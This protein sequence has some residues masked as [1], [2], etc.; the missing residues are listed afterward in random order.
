LGKR[1]TYD[2]YVNMPDDGNR[3]EIDD[4]VLMVMEPAPR[5]QHQ[6]LLVRLVTYFELNCS[7]HGKIL[8]APVDVK[9]AD[10]NT[11]QPDLVFVSNERK[12]IITEM[13]IEGAPDLVVEI[14]SPSTGKRDKTKKKETY[15]RFGV[16]EYWVL[17]PFYELLEQFI[18]KDGGYQLE[19]VY[20]PD[21]TVTS[22]HFSCIN[23]PLGELFSE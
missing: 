6:E 15:E 13:A 9:F 2:D 5:I 20:K 4:G 12:S 21:D 17:D 14:L 3:Y 11:K 1:V 23:L 19:Q 18:L 10:D 22:P 7:S 16:K 8:P